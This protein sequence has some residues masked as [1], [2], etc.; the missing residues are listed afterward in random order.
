[1]R[2]CY[3]VARKMKIAQ[4]FLSENKNVGY[5]LVSMKL[6]SQDK[7][8]FSPLMF[9]GMNPSAQIS[10]TKAVYLNERPTG[11]LLM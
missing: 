2:V 4:D 7:Q 3:S 5:L 8:W 11:R 10:L 1:M 9:K 6:H